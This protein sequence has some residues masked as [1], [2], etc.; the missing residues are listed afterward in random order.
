MVVR[1]FYVDVTTSPSDMKK[2]FVAWHEHLTAHDAIA[3]AFGDR[4]ANSVATDLMQDHQYLIV[5]WTNPVLDDHSE[6][7][8]V[9]SL[10]W[11]IP[12]Q[13][14]LTIF[15]E[16]EATPQNKID[17]AIQWLLENENSDSDC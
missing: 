6:I 13:T 17:E 7:G 3:L 16:G 15:Y 10:E 9:G 14:V 2:A 8:G 4:L 1:L 12:D 5:S 11:S